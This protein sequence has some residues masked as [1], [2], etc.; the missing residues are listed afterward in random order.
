MDDCRGR[1]TISS[2]IQ[3]R[4][5]PK[6]N[7]GYNQFIGNGQAMDTE[8]IVKI[9]DFFASKLEDGEYNLKDVSQ[10]FCM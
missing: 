9:L 10:K 1:N 5:W 7:S 3:I 2:A 6:L 4:N 8:G